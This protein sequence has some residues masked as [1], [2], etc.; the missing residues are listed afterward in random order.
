LDDRLEARRHCVSA[1]AL[2]DLGARRFRILTLPLPLFLVIAMVCIALYNRLRL[3]PRILAPQTPI[4][5]RMSMSVLYRTVA[6]EQVIGLAVLAT[7]STFGT[8][9]PVS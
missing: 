3:S 4:V 5:N 8:I 6:A 1:A 9:H 7:T 2:S